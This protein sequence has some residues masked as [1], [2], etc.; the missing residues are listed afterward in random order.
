ML[1][2]THCHINMMVK[3]EFETDLSP[4]ELTLAKPIIDE[5]HASEVNTII[6]VGTSLIESQNSVLLAQTF[7]S[8]YATIGIHPND[9]TATWKKDFDELK[10]MITHDKV[11]GVGECGIDMHYQGYDLK[12]QDYAFRAHLELALEHHK[13]VVVH[14]RDAAQETLRI[15][16]DYNRDLKR[17][18][19]HCFSYNLE[20]AEQV[21]RWGFKI[22]IDAP[23]T[24]TKN[25]EL[26]SIVASVRLEDIVL[27]TDAP[28]LPIQ[29][30]RGKQ[31]APKYIKTIAEYIATLKK[32]EFDTVARITTNNARELFN[33]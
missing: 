29:E 3:K 33:L 14:S 13:A 10:K 15:L 17:V 2:D 1:I 5:A 22:G 24:Y 16:D 28:F 26:R 30:M 12:R 7:K 27:E 9:C 32:E 6:N 25:N 4:H 11:V 20:I 19:L 31:N 8:V 18:V 23:I 21:I